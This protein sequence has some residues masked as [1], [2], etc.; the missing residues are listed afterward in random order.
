M[1]VIHT[2]RRPWDAQPQ[3]AVR[4]ADAFAGAGACLLPSLCFVDLVSGQLWTPFG[5]TPGASV[6]G[7][8]RAVDSTGA[9]GGLY[10]TP[11]IN[12]SGAAQTHI[13]IAQAVSNTG[14][15]AGLIA[16]ASADGS[17]ASLSLQKS[18]LTNYYY[19]SGGTDVAAVSAPTIDPSVIVV[20]GDAAGTDVWVGGALALSTGSGPVARSNSRVILLG[21]RSASASYATLGRVWL[22]LGLPYRLDAPTT[23]AIAL[24]PPEQL[25]GAVFA[26]L[27][28]PVWMSAAALA[29]ITLQSD[30]SLLH[31]PS[32][33]GGDNKLYLSTAGAIV[34]KAAPGAGDQRISISGG[35]WL[36]S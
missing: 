9:A 7:L 14:N 20:A 32:P 35:N 4:L 29:A 13:L 12:L 30:G 16:S 10:L 17:S 6:Q 11:T 25:Y 28:R 26:P 18:T 5:T 31:K 8:G 19:W 21:E 33:A 27:D 23:R 22:Y 3:R 34:A 36:A 2:L 1:G 24:T 15:Y